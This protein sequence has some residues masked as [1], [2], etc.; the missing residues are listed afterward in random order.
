MA[1]KATFLG[2]LLRI[3]STQ[4]D[5]FLYRAIACAHST[6]TALDSLSQLNFNGMLVT[7][8]LPPEP[9]LLGASPM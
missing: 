4:G 3:S 8:Y 5:L 6:N 9:R 2:F 7:K 1:I